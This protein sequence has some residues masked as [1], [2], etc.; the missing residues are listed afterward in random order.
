MWI[1]YVIE[2]GDNWEIEYRTYT[3]PLVTLS[4]TVVDSN[5]SDNAINLSGECW[6]LYLLR[7]IGV[8]IN[9]QYHRQL[10]PYTLLATTLLQNL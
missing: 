6:S 8:A 3:Q 2:D 10:L 7:D 1:R 9:K 5:N 4:R